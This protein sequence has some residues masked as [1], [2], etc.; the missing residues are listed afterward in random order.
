MKSFIAAL[1]LLL[2]PVTSYGALS[3]QEKAA[4]AHLDAAS[5][6]L[7]TA[8]IYPTVVV[9]EVHTVSGNRVRVADLVRD[10]SYAHSHINRV[11]G[12]LLGIIPETQF[13]PQYDTWNALPRSEQVALWMSFLEHAVEFTNRAKADA[14]LLRP[15]ASEFL[16]AQLNSIEYSLDETLRSLNAVD[17]SL[18][19]TDPYPQ[20]PFPN[21][22]HGVIGPHGDVKEALWTL[23]R[24]GVY[25]GR[26]L[27]HLS[28]AIRVGPA[29][30]PGNDYANHG[31]PFVNV[32]VSARQSQWIMRVIAGAVPGADPGVR[33]FDVLKAL[34]E[35]WSHTYP[36]VPLHHHFLC[37]TWR[38]LLFQRGR[39]DTWM[40]HIIDADVIGRDAWAHFDHA[41]KGILRF[42]DCSV[43]NN[44]TGC[45]GT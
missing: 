32:L 29:P 26:V 30:V 44:P 41:V 12:G 3:S 40:T 43:L 25:W 36:N 15:G 1:C 35:G 9:V 24:S 16:A 22:I 18:L 37:L 2:A 4:L 11:L 17:R 34:E 20:P 42:P 10:I 7:T 45:G 38:D 14:Q 28:E 39:K 31:R 33:F 23:W 6:A 13:T 19:F 27:W 8:A 21:G 5:A